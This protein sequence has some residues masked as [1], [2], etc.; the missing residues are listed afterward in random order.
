M[1]FAYCDTGPA[2]G[3]EIF[4]ERFGHTEKPLKR[5]FS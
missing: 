5:Y 3:M 1:W 4:T 2:I